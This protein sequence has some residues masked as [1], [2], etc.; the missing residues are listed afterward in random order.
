VKIAC[1]KRL[2]WLPS[3]VPG[4]RRFRSRPSG[5]VREF[6]IMASTLATGTRMSV[7]E[8]RVGSIWSSEVSGLWSSP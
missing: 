7:P 6:I 2:V 3:S 4:N 1:A 8:S 5:E